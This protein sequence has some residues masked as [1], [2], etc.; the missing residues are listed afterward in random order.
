MCTR[1]GGG[2][3]VKEK[4]GGGGRQCLEIDFA[5]VCCTF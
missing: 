5:A 3:G 4:V 1:V 2:V